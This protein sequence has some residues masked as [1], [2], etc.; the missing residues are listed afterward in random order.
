MEINKKKQ[1]LLS[2]ISCYQ[3]HKIL[4][5]DKKTIFYVEFILF[6]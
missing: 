1:K 6:L 3:I 4:I 5:K 2:Y